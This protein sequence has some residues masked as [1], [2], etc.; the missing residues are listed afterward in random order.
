[1]STLVI[2]HV[3]SGRPNP[4]WTLD[5]NQVAELSERITG[6]RRLTTNK[7]AGSLGHLGY[8]GFSVRRET[9]SPAGRLGLLIHEGVVDQGQDEPNLL[10]GN[11]EIEEWLLLTAGARVPAA[12]AEH[13]REDTQRP[14]TPAMGLQEFEIP[15]AA[16]CPKC[17]AADAP[18]Y[19]PSL[20]NIPSVQP[21]NNCYN[22]AN[23][24]ATNTFAQPG[25]AHGTPAT[26]MSCP[27]VQ[28]SAQADG[29]VPCANFATPLAK[30]Q[31]WYVALVIW[32]GQDYH[33]YR[34][35]NVGCWSHKPGQTAVRNYDNAGKPISDPNTCNRGPYTVFC[36]Y[37]VT[38]KSVVIR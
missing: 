8:R 34:Q 38:N 27:G 19:S 6:I 30:G 18:P 7:P 35:D 36:T 2:L 28:P 10:A 21:Y 32:P 5:D 25:R 23:N 37:M 12:V 20:W 15:Q 14:R 11:R 33:W 24:Q 4:T 13:V 3:F 16:G 1:M 17:V 29:L 9:G 26:S 31:G 22:Y